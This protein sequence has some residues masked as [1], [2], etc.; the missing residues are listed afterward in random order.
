MRIDAQDVFTRVHRRRVLVH[1]RPPRPPHE[2]NDLAVAVV[3]GLLHGPQLRV[4]D[5]RHL[6][7]GV[8]RRPRRER[9]IHLHAALVER[10]QEVSAQPGKL[11]AGKRHA[12]PRCREEQSRRR[13][14]EPDQRCG[15]RLQGPQQQPVLVMVGRRRV[16]QQVIRQH[17]RHGQR[18]EQRREDRHDV[19]HAE[20]REQPALDSGEREQRQK[21][22]DH[23]GGA[24]HDGTADLAAGV[25][26]DAEGRPRVGQGVVLLEAP[27][28]V[29]DVDD[30]V[31]D[32]FAHGDGDAAERHHVDGEMRAS[33]HSGDPEDERRDDQRQR[34][35]RERDERRPQIHEEQ[36]QHDQYQHRPDQE[37][38]ADVEDAPVDEALEPEKF[39]VHDDVGREGGLQ[40]AKR[41][42]DP[43]GEAARV[44]VGLL[45]DGE[46][47]AGHTVDSTVAAFELRALQDVGHLSQ[48]DRAFGV[49]G[50]RHLAEILED[51]GRVG[52]EPS[53]HPDW[54]LLLAVDGEPAARVDVA[55]TQGLLD[56]LQRHT[57]FEH[58]RGVGEDLVLLAVAPLNEHLGD[59]RNFQEAGP[60]DP[61]GGGAQVHRLL[62][63]RG[64]H[65]VMVTAGDRERGCPRGFR[66]A[67]GIWASGGREPP[68]ALHRNPLPRGGAMAVDDL[69]RPHRW[70]SAVAG[71]LGEVG[72]PGDDGEIA[73][74]W[75]RLAVHAG[76]HDLPHD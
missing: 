55:V 45:G 59:T 65:H 11:P 22:E 6:I 64:E 60:H 40:F 68:G 44:D 71:H 53:Q 21:H 62:E 47:D 74:L 36:E 29:L 52:A 35:R 1:F 51:A 33:Q 18:H 13:H 76:D 67:V 72:C 69:P 61:V 57:V 12:Q 23:H 41:L 70:F 37:R 7:R 54:S 46:H 48:K 3:G 14:A 49:H 73:A 63:L 56:H 42:A 30:G 26:D 50:D 15:Q 17:G 16:R 10:R 24:E 25:V 38:F 5:C 34:D 31:V 43:V 9:D 2:M 27:E 28:D 20:G 75:A 32:E 4:D 58:G 8:E 66:L 39:R 19:G